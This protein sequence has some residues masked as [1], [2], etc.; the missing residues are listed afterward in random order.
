MIYTTHRK[1]IDLCWYCVSVGSLSQ[2]N[3][4]IFIMLL[5]H[6]H[7]LNCKKV[8]STANCNQ[9]NGQWFHKGYIKAFDGLLWFNF[10]FCVLPIKHS[11]FYLFTLSLGIVRPN[12]DLN[13]QYKAFCVT[14]RKRG[15]FYY[16]HFSVQLHTIE[17]LCVSRWIVYLIQFV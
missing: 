2:Q 13:I 5:N 12:F 3:L 16:L 7:K 10:T 6:V 8:C 4:M 14:L 1:P 17:N 15:P 9:F 11:T